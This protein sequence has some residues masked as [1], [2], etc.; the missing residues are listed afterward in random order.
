MRSA[1][2]AIYAPYVLETAIS[3]ETEPPGPAEIG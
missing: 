3:F 2:A 1:C